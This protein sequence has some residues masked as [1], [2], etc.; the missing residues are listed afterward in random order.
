MLAPPLTMW[1][2]VKVLNRFLTCAI[3]TILEPT[4]PG[5]LQIKSVNVC[6]EL[7]T[8]LGT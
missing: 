8:R 2:G 3:G 6:K 4:S 1:P 7:R 5:C